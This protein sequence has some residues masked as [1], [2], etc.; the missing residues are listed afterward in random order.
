[1]SP[2]QVT[3]NRSTLGLEPHLTNDGATDDLGY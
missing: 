1:M 2:I 3:I